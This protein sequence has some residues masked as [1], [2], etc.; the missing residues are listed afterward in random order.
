VTSD[1][2]GEQA[3]TTVLSMNFLAE[4]GLSQGSAL[5]LRLLPD[6]IRCFEQWAA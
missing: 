3:L 1:S 6:R 5:A 4:H 2:L